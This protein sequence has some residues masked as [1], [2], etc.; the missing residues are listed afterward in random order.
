MISGGAVNSPQLL[1]L[2]GIGPAA[3]L[4]KLGIPVVHDLPGVGKNLQNHVS[5]GLDYTVPTRRSTSYNREDV[6][7]YL[8]NQTGPLSSTGLAQ[9]TGIL[10]SKFTTPD[11]PD[12]QFFFSGYQESCVFHAAHDVMLSSDS[13]AIRFTAV[14]LHTKSRG[15]VGFLFINTQIINQLIDEKLLCLAEQVRFRWPARILSSTR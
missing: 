13:E 15:I 6:D 10:S 11:D 3:E 12:M 1:L 7:L 2:S 8:S 9:M 5:Y 14:N 4:E